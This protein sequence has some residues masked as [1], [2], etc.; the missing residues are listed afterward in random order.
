MHAP[1]LRLYG[2]CPA[3]RSFVV[4]TGALESETKNDKRLN[5][6]KREDVVRFIRAN[7]L[8]SS[9]FRGDILAV[10]PPDD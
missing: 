3:Q 1:G 6:R 9:V 5:D 8:Q 10:F 4:V 2:W 7:D